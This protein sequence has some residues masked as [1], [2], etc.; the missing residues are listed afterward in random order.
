MFTEVIR[1]TPFTDEIAETVCDNI[2][3][4]EYLRDKS[5]L[6]TARAL[7]LP[8]M[9]DGDILQITINQ[10]HWAKSSIEDAAIDTAMNAMLPSLSPNTL[11]IVELTRDTENNSYIIDYITEHI[12]EFRNVKQI[13]KVSQFYA[14]T[15]KC[16]CFVDEEH[17]QTYLYTD[18]LNMRLFHYLQCGILIYL[19]WFFNKEEGITQEE[20]KLIES[21]RLNTPD[22]YNEC[23]AEM[24]KNYDFRERYTRK[25]LIGLET[26]IEKNELARIQVNIE[27][28]ERNI[29]EYSAEIS[30]L[31][32]R[33]K[34]ANIRMMGLEYKIRS[35][36]EDGRESEIMRYFL[37]NNRLFL[38][39]AGVGQFM[40]DV[41]DYLMF[42]DEDM[43]RKMIDNDR[44]YAYN[45][46]REVCVPYTHDELKRLL[47][48]I[49]VENNFKIRIC[50]TYDFNLA[51]MYVRAVSHP[52]YGFEFNDCTPNPHIDRYSCLGS[53][54][55]SINKFLQN[56]DYIGAI[57]QCV[58]SCRSLNFGDGAVMKEFFQRWY[59]ISDYPEVN[60]RCIEL[61]N[62]EVATPEEAIEYMRKQDESGQESEVADG[63]DN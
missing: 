18:R 11:S 54:E 30:N 1:S 41:K 19:P 26:Q 9:S 24:V 58:A 33:L 47:E 14:K 40:F 62:G 53:Y 56:C 49:F 17:R 46:G 37:S 4:G 60:M 32:K 51:G 16:V 28:W 44:S 22:Q 39:S 55:G 36:E 5:F 12:K 52:T 45:P 20:R 43:A 59:G 42:W 3:G 31:M 8:R 57:E 15:F 35:D 61:P 25:A 7:L 23:L 48:E 34:D 2:Y 6:A 13:E 10:D 63:E 27:D 50:A 21:L 29:R 38:R